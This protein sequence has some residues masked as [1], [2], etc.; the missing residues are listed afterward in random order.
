[1]RIF[2]PNGPALV[3]LLPA[4]NRFSPLSLPAKIA[5]A[6]GRSQRWLE[7]A[8]ERAQLQRHFAIEPLPW[9]VAALTR[10][11]DVGDA[12][13]ALWLR[14]DPV[15]VQPDQYSARMMAYGPSLSAEDEDVKALLPE[16][17]ALFSEHGWLLDA[18]VP[19]RWY[20]RLPDA[21]PLPELSDLAHV[22]GAD[23][24]AHLPQG[25][26]GRIWRALLSDSQVLLHQHRHNSQRLAQ[27]KPAINSLWFW[28]AGRLPETVSSPYQ[29]IR[30]PDTL[31]RALA[32]HAAITPYQNTS[33]S[34]SSMYTLVDL[35]HISHLQTLI[36]QAL[37][38]LLNALN[39]GEMTTLH[40]DFAD[41]AQY[42]LYRGQRW[43]FW[44]KP[45]LQL[46]P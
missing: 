46:T 30:S 31:L 45:V 24:F 15:N 2:L 41:G 19:S 34:I 25:E 5:S 42:R 1:M 12:G 38:P 17:Q 33:S 39:Q 13:N 22:L 20:L 18:P 9:S 14:A 44:A 26:H 37:M 6:L 8:G 32:Q 28:G 23:L 36:D 21:V 4:R 3:V 7:H 10:H 16:L 43:K 40:L 29:H 35:R 27:G 11:Y